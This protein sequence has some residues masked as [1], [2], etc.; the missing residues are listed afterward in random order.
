[1]RDALHFQRM[2]IPKD[3][4]GRYVPTGTPRVQGGGK[5]HL[6][7]YTSIDRPRKKH[8]QLKL[9]KE[10][11]AKQ[12][13]LTTKIR[14]MNKSTRKQADKDQDL[15]DIKSLEVNIIAIEQKLHEI[16]E[17][18][19]E[20]KEKRAEGKSDEDTDESEPD[21]YSDRV[22]L[23][24][25]TDMT[26]DVK[27]V[28]SKDAALNETMSEI[29][30]GPSVSLK[31]LNKIAGEA[32]GS[33]DSDG[34]VLWERLEDTTIV[35]EMKIIFDK[36]AAHGWEMMDNNAGNFMWDGKKLTRIDFRRRF[37]RRKADVTTEVS[38]KQMMDE[39]ANSFEEQGLDAD[40]WKH[41]PT[42][43]KWIQKK[44]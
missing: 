9:E 4:S 29:G 7:A 42:R 2:R 15:T 10:L 34:K 19:A 27:I 38:V 5:K 41:L 25:T 36:V 8:T 20:G 30:I 44:K 43:K 28:S 18:R 12:R 22:E 23:F 1:M 35:K 16:K 33:K 24:N 17:K 26:K 31:K 3:G 6:S 32:L 39:I 37:N 21:D 40:L 13:Q 14:T 11:K